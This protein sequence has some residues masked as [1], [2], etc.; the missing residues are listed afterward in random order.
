MKAINFERMMKQI[1]IQF[2]LLTEALSFIDTGFYFFSSFIGLLLTFANKIRKE[3]VRNLFQFLK[4]QHLEKMLVFFWFQI[5]T[6]E[7]I[8]QTIEIRRSEKFCTYAGM[9]QINTSINDI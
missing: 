5:K 3:M 9:N 4:N 6:L 7:L 2:I 8:L 1:K